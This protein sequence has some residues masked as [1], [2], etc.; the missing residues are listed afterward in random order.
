M[1]EKKQTQAYPLRM[2]SALR[3]A[4]ELAA[5]ESKRSV[6][7]EIVSRLEMSLLADQ[8]LSEFLSVERIR[9]ISHLEEKNLPNKIRESLQADILS[10]AKA[11]ASGVSTSC[12]GLG[13]VDGNPAHEAM[14]AEIVE[15]LRAAGYRVEQGY[16]FD[17][18]ISFYDRDAD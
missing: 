6:N 16:S 7:A 3:E 9:E 13:L 2:S 4:V 10:A 5:H 12:E 1:S 17:V 14:I 18:S 15:E 8:R 11:G